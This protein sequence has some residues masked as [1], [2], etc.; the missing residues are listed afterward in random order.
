[1]QQKK[2]FCERNKL[3]YKISIIK[4]YLLRDLKSLLSKNK[5]AKILSQDKLPSIVKGHRSMIVRKLYGVDIQ[6]Q[7]NKK[8]NLSLASKK[9]NGIIIK[10][11]EVFSFWKTVG[12]ATKRKGYLEGLT[13]SGGGSLSGVGGGLCQVA[14]MIHWLIL[15]SPVEVTELHHHSDALFPD[16]ERKVPFGTGTSVFYKNIDYQFKNTTD[17][18]IQILLWIDD[19]D[20][21]GELRS[22][23]PFP[24]RYKITEENNHFI[25]E[26]DAYFRISQVYRIV[27]DK[28]TNEPI[29]K[30]M[31]LDN[32]S[33]VMYD[34]ALIPIDQIRTHKE[35]L[36]VS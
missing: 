18:R 25:R 4:E 36:C 30:E 17:Q 11:G 1:M 5:F 35:E 14:N 22:E 16:E 19:T 28:Q 23:R 34:H 7:Y 10:P 12:N 9:I 21:C 8:T 32:H 27:I 13:I 26:D 2:L 29:A 6:L 15:H 24:Y 31:V 20:L 3:C 33:K